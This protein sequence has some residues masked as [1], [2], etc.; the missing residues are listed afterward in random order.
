MMRELLKAAGWFAVFMAAIVVASAAAMG[1]D[2]VGLP[3]TCALAGATAM[4][5]VAVAV[6]KKGPSE[7]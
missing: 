1:W 3:F 2:K 6:I 7:N 5:G 4:F